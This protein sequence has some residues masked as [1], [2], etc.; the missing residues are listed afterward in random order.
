MG[1]ASRK[2]SEPSHTCVPTS[3]FKGPRQPP[4]LAHRWVEKAPAEERLPLSGAIWLWHRTAFPSPNA[5]LVPGWWNAKASSLFCLHPFVF[6][7]Q[8]TEQTS[9]S[10]EE[11]E[12]TDE[13]RSAVGSGQEQAALGKA[14]GKHSEILYPARL[15]PRKVKGC[16]LWNC[17]PAFPR[18]QTSGPRSASATVCT[19]RQKPAQRC[20]CGLGLKG[21]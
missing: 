15:S 14:R 9:E 4:S 2:S 3:C 17:G 11:D 16:C 6:T 18:A 12:P 1:G 21:H 8:G 10:G 5:R 13:A 19:I 7:Q 20:D